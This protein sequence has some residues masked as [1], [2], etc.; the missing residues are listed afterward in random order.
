MRAPVPV[1]RS[2]FSRPHAAAGANGAG[3][4]GRGASGPGGDEPASGGAN[5]RSGSGSSV[6]GIER[7]SHGAIALGALAILFWLGR[8]KETHRL[9]APITH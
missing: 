8:A 4:E 6:P 1:R 5:E 7:R 2:R 3:A 9:A